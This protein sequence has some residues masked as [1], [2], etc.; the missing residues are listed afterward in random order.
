[1]ILMIKT[2]SKSDL[3]PWL[4]E[5]KYI[6]LFGVKDKQIEEELPKEIQKKGYLERADFEKLLSWKFS[7]MQGRLKRSLNLLAKNS[8]EDLIQKTSH[9]FALSDEKEKIEVLKSIKGVGN[10]VGSV[11][12]TFYD[13]R[14]YAVFDIHAWRELFGPEPKDYYKTSRLIEF[15]EEIRR[16]SKETGLTCREVEKAIFT[17]NYVQNPKQKTSSKK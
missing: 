14:K 16:I 6:E 13:S 15:F 12:L 9:A 1:M 4:D 17:K 10:A 5:D 3:L 2:F 7:T 8:N 11:I